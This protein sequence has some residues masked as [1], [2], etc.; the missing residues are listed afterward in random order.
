MFIGN[1]PGNALLVRIKHQHTVI[2]FMRSRTNSGLT[3]HRL[4]R[5]WLQVAIS[6]GALR[7]KTHF[8]NHLLL[9]LALM[10]SC[11]TT[12]AMLSGYRLKA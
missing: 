8:H 4:K 1:L 2:Q 10:H 5:L 7:F 12:G 3:D 9:L 6:C 11:S